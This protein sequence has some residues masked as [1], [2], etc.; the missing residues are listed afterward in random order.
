MFQISQ[1]ILMRHQRMKLTKNF[2]G[3]WKLAWTRFNKSA[4]WFQSFTDME[5]IN[6]YQFSNINILYINNAVCSAFFGHLILHFAL[7]PR[8]YSFGQN[9]KYWCSLRV[10]WC[11]I[12]SFLFCFFVGVFL[13]C[14]CVCMCV[15]MCVYSGE[16]IG[17]QFYLSSFFP[18]QKIKQIFTFV[19]FNFFLMHRINEK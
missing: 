19:I 16:Q 3:V 12:L 1:K 6:C 4:M 13:V 17:K 15:G 9:T 11:L 10:F 2:S 8:I 7:P 5:N 14:V 18:Q